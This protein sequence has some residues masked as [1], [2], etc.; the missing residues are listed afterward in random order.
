M[1]IFDRVRRGANEGRINLGSLGKTVGTATL[2][3]LLAGGVAACSSNKGDE[4]IPKKVAEKQ[5]W[6]VIEVVDEYIQGSDAQLALVGIGT[7]AEDGDDKETYPCAATV[8]M[9]SRGV[10]M[11]LEPEKGKEFVPGPTAT[12]LAESSLYKYCFDPATGETTETPAP[13]KGQ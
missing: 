9:D 11:E 12:N 5:G 7:K 8:E 13:E 3:L 4:P 2:A 6:K 1:E 10:H